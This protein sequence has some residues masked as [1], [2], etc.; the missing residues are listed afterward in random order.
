MRFIP[1][2]VE[3]VQSNAG[4]EHNAF[5]LDPVL[6]VQGYFQGVYPFADVVI[7]AD[8][9]YGAVR[10]RSVLNPGPPHVVIRNIYTCFD[11]V[12]ARYLAGQVRLQIP[13]GPLRILW[14]EKGAVHIEITV[15]GPLCGGC[16]AVPCLYAA[17]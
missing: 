16:R 15:S 8:K 7:P 17:V 5:K 14:A 3:A 1:A 12:G 4:I 11:E 10:F 13:P 6:Q 9:S 2:E